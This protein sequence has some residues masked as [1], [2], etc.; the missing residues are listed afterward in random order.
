MKPWIS[1]AYLFLQSLMPIIFSHST[2]NIPNNWMKGDRRKQNELNV[3]LKKTAIP[4]QRTKLQAHDNQ[5]FWPKVT[6]FHSSALAFAQ[7]NVSCCT[8]HKSFTYRTWDIKYTRNENHPNR[9]RCCAQ[10][11][12]RNYFYNGAH[13][14]IH[15]CMRLRDRR[16][17]PQQSE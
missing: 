14:N 6:T 4:R 1:R 10:I 7:Q 9:V 15:V 3:K 12:F 8:H 17:C 16:K 2:V 11:L 5:M 13:K